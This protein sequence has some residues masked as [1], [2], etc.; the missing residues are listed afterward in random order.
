V[1]ANTVNDSASAER[2]SAAS[3][4]RILLKPHE[5]LGT[6]DGQR[7][8]STTKVADPAAL[9]KC[10]TQHPLFEVDGVLR[11]ELRMDAYVTVGSKRWMAVTSATALRR[12]M[13]F[14]AIVLGALQAWTSRY[15]ISTHDGVSYLDVADAYLRAD[16]QAALNG[17]WSPLYSWLLALMLGLLE[18]TTYWELPALKL[19]NFLIYVGAA[20]AFDFFLRALIAHNEQQLDR[21]DR[22]RFLRVPEWMW[23]VLGYSLFLWS[24]LE[25]T[26]LYSD[27]PDLLSS[28]FV[29]LAAGILL[30]AR[31]G[32]DGWLT[33]VL[34]GVVLGLGYLSK[35][36]MLPISLVFLGAGFFSVTNFRRAVPRILLAGVTLAFVS[37]PFVAAISA[38]EG[39]F[40]FGESGK[41]AY[42]L[43]VNP[44]GD[45][46][47]HSHWQG[48]QPEFGTPEHTTRKIYESPAVF[49]FGT[50]VA[51][52]YPP[53]YDPSYWHAGLEIHVDLLQQVKVV[54]WNALFAWD[55]FLAA[56]I[57]G[58]LALILAADRF[59]PSLAALRSNVVILAPA[60][61]GLFAYFLAT[62]LPVSVTPTQ[63]PMRY[64][65]AFAVL[66]YAGAFCSVRLPDSRESRRWLV[67]MTV[68]AAS[69]VAATLISNPI[70]DRLG[71]RVLRDHVNWR[72]ASELADLGVRPGDVVASMGL[73]DSL[74]WA[75]LAG[76]RI[77]AEVTGEHDFWSG[78]PQTR[79]DVLRALEQTGAKAVVAQ[80][81]FLDPVLAEEEGWQIIGNGNA[82]VYLFER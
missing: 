22:A 42:A 49:E 63:P 73:G 66:L 75:R 12:W 74:Y 77:V 34:L 47:H 27:T 31:G 72:I 43:M 68:A 25:W 46:I 32:A 65:S 80:L 1:H 67:G 6:P 79:A 23:I 21:V 5:P 55:N 10:E 60:A 78:K 20:L 51:G 50:P 53:W 14:A 2:E 76:V 61:G 41:L 30:R 28:V 52:S 3:L 38:K 19:L 15:T 35:T 62:D 39:R 11:E 54:V 24:A 70:R 64:L 57:F 16:W 81:K 18:P 69:V 56:L 36:V 13:W 4:V 8:R 71:G 26:T 9:T 40:M 82:Y 37:A 59:R 45:V 17:Y 48:E 44:G 58:Y 7:E 33:F 29:Y